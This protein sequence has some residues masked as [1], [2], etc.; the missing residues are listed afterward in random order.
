[1][2]GDA[3]DIYIDCDGDGSMDDLNR[4]GRI[5]G[6]DSITLARWIEEVWTL[7]QFEE[8]QGGLGI[9]NGTGSHGP[10]VH[11]DLR[12]RKARWGGNGLAW[13]DDEPSSESGTLN[14]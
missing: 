13:D 12:G 3:A 1:M 7:P 9:Y 5:D 2:Y 6:E 11:V 14:R 4:D 10:F 8:R